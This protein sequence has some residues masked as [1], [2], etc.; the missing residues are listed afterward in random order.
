MRDGLKDFL[1]A[2]ADFYN[3]RDFIEPDPVSIPHLF[4]KKQ[5]IEIAG[6][7]AAVLAWGQRK[8]ILNKCHEL[9]ARMDHAPFDFI[10]GHTDTDLKQLLG[11]KHRTF[12]DTDL[13][14]F[15][16]FFRHH[17][18]MHDSL[19]AA[20]I[21]K[22]GEFNAD[23]LA[24]E[25]TV[26]EDIDRLSSLVCMQAELSFDLKDAL[27]NFRQVFF[28]LPDFPERTKKHIS[29]PN[30]N[31]TCKRLCM[32][33][34]WMVRSDD[35][36]VDFGI[37]KTLLP[38]QLICP[39]DVHVDRVARSLGLIQRKQ[40]DWITAVELTEQLRKFD[41]L[42]PVKYDFALFGLGVERALL[43]E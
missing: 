3:R 22:R 36:G 37:W 21:P 28:S 33:L 25:A 9:M 27:N 43:P 39:C 8:T 24:I 34:R 38:A 15:V 10:K 20:F 42:D 32:F 31:S 16:A 5:D 19:E 29:S 26:S 4:S 40:T 17:Y 30:Q 18:E 11:F 13:L 1:E 23:Y 14:Y 12:N 7:F 35:R 2:K 6:F 41:P